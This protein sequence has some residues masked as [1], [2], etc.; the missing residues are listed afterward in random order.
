MSLRRT[1][2]V[3]IALVLLV[4]LPFRA[5]AVIG[6]CESAHETTMPAMDVHA[7]DQGVMHDDMAMLV[8]PDHATDHGTCSVCCCA[9][10]IASE[11]F[12][13]PSRPET[14]VAPPVVATQTTP[15]VV[16]G[17]LER[18]PRSSTA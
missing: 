8:H 5:N 12:R 11:S 1:I 15:L 6:G 17:G 3:R 14:R 9:A 4:A 13:W 2:L 16:L 10:V 18:P 7:M